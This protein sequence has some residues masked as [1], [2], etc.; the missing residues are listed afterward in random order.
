MVGIML[1]TF[2]FLEKT[3]RCVESLR[4]ATGHPYK[5]LLIDNHST[6]GT[7]DYARQAGLRAIANDR[8]VSLTRA[9]NQ[10]LQAF[11]DDPEVE[12]IAWIHNDML[13]FPGWLE[14]L[15]RV[16]SRPEIGKLAPWN[17]M[18]DPAQYSDEWAA[19]FMQEHKDELIPGN[20]CPWIMRKEVAGRVGLFDEDFIQCGGCEDW[21]YNN[22]AA[23]AGYFVGT[24][25][26]SVVWH[27]GMGTRNYVDN[28]DACF[29]NAGVYAR[30][31][32]SRPWI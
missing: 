14:G 8:E 22:R 32:G 6:D 1:T 12:F 4:R 31:W 9:L 29:H 11:L 13:F 27:E 10:G 16:A 18:G 19:K 7:P 30:K 25:G 20:N 15:V 23:D 5:L 17:V 24:T 28:R 2:N 26:A 3:R 21:D